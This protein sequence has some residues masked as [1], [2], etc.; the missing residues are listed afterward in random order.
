MKYKI[1]KKSP[2]KNYTEEKRDLEVI[3]SGALLL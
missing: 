1:Y 3:P 2:E